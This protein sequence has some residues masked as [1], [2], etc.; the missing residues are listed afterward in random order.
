MGILIIGHLWKVKL[1]PK[2]IIDK[3]E[4]GT[5][6]LTQFPSREI[7]IL[8]TLKNAELEQVVT[9]EVVHALL[10]EFSCSNLGNYN[11]EFVCDFIA[12]NIIMIKDLATEIIYILNKEV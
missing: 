10:N 5:L 8:D 2:E 7:W 9:H 12:N 6:G 4:I 11:D 1:K 3:E